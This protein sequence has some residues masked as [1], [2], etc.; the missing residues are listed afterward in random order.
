MSMKKFKH[1][2]ASVRGESFC[3]STMTYIIMVFNSTLFLVIVT[4]G[5]AAYRATKTDPAEAMRGE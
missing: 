3:T 1:C 2:Y 5:V 4:S